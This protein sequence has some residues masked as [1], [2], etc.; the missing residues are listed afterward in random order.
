V[1]SKVSLRSLRSKN[2]IISPS[3]SILLSVYLAFFMKSFHD[4][5]LSK[6]MP[7]NLIDSV[8]VRLSGTTFGLL[9]WRCG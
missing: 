1:R 6:Y 8:Q 9:G 7:K 2:S 3:Y 4:K 5:L